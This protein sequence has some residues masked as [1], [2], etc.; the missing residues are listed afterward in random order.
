[1][2]G[3]ATA[4]SFAQG[5]SMDLT[6]SIF[7]L[8]Y[9]VIALGKV[10]GLMVDRTGAAVLGAIALIVF[11]QIGIDEAWASIDVKTVALLFGLMVL[12]SAFVVSGFYASAASWV[13][14]LDVG[15]KT[16]LAAFICVSAFLS[17]L[18][19]NDVVVLAMTPLLLAVTI[20]RG[21]NP[22]PFLLAFCF[23]SNTGAVGTPIG[24]PQNMILGEGLHL[25]FVDFAKVTLGPALLSLPLVWFVVVLLYRKR[26]ILR[27]TA[28]PIV[29]EPAA[30]NS[31]ET[32]KALAVTLAVVL[33]F[34]LTDWPRALVALAAAGFLLMNRK[35]S[36]TDMLKHVNGDLMLLLFGLF[37]LNAALAQ[38]GLPVR[39]LA[40]LRQHGFDLQ[41][42]LALFLVTSVLSNIVGNNPAVMLL[43]PYMSGERND[44]SAAAMALGTGFSSNMIIFGS[45]AG[46]IVVEEARKRGV[47]ISFREFVR[48]GLPVALACIAL[49]IGWLWWISR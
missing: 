15:P 48:A 20:E 32:G 18:L 22:T 5:F 35:I 42:P 34:V 31:M 6:V 1:L 46:I 11:E 21:L 14:L 43:V 13:A 4:C 27:T 3:A 30:F 23:A 39:L 47:T 10:P 24:S 36:S 12:S 38:T 28:S 41:Q 45:L 25:S 49:A 16:L 19:T 29:D 26:W 44:L 33:A 8:S 37:V 9:F 7:V 17:A 40:D 2:I